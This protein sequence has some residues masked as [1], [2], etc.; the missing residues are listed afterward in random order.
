MDGSCSDRGAAPV[1]EAMAC[2]TALFAR[3]TIRK[4]GD[5]ITLHDVRENR[6]ASSRSGLYRCH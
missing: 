2:R 1:M 6:D 5:S 3:L 4:P